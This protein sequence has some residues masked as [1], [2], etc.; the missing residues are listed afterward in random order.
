LFFYGANT[1]VVKNLELLELTDSENGTI[2][3]N[4]NGKNCT[5]KRLTLGRPKNFLGSVGILENTFF[6]WP[7]SYK[8]LKLSMTQRQS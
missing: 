7:K 2:Y 6:V 4:E 8:Q 5:E 3:W 1:A